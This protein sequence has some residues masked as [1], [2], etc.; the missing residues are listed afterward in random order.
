MCSLY[1]C[2]RKFYFGRFF[3]ILEMVVERV[4]TTS[5]YICNKNENEDLKDEY[6]KN[7]RIG[8]TV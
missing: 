6:K 8:R 4:E 5:I 2:H 1:T 3:L 7:R